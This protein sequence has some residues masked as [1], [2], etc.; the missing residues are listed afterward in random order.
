MGTLPHWLYSYQDTAHFM[1]GKQIADNPQRIKEY[2]NRI[3]SYL[4]TV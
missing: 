3:F 2:L 1:L 4:F